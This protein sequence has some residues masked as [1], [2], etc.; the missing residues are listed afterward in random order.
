MTHA[1][2]LP[3]SLH[4]PWRS[5]RRE[6]GVLPVV[7][8]LVTVVAAAAAGVALAAVGGAAGP[9]AM[10]LLPLVV[11]ACAAV[12]LRPVLGVA[13]VVVVLPFGLQE[14]PGQGLG[15]QVMQVVAVVAVGAAVVGRAVAGQLPLVIPKQLAWA[16]LLVAWGLVSYLSA[17]DRGIATRQLLQLGVN[18]TLALLVATTVTSEREL[19]RLLWLVVAVG[20]LSCLPALT[21]A[22]ELRASFGGAVVA[23]RLE[24]TFTQ[25]NEFGSF[26]M[27]VVVL[28]AALVVGARTRRES[29]LLL[30]ALVPAVGGLLLS[31]SRGAWIGAVAGALVLLV[32]LPPARRALALAAVPVL[33]AGA[34]LGAL[35]P[36]NPQVQVVGSRVSTLAESGGGNPYDDRPRIWAEGRREVRLDPLTGHGPGAFPVVSTRSASQAQTVQAEHAHSVLLTVAAEYG[37]PGAALLVALGVACGFAAHA[38]ARRA[39]HRTAALVAGPAAAAV[40]IAA[41]G[42][43]DYTMRNAVLFT[44]FWL[45]AGLLVAAC[46]VALDEPATA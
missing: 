30:A 10:L 46:R 20:G 5:G 41:Q 40:A 11:V 29:L 25:P 13:V 36:E 43:I 23:N 2:L 8:G 6:R 16:V 3:V 22:G 26:A 15:L 9:L 24:G 42:V 35:A 19:R 33:V 45:V 4:M 34:A 27:V 28:G 21:S 31:L 38:A 44:F 32:L 37:L 12:V 7:A 39:S 18:V 1:G 14:L 17:V